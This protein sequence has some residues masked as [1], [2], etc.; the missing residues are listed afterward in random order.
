[1]RSLT[2]AEVELLQS[3]DVNGACDFVCEEESHFSEGEESL[4]R[5]L[6][7]EGRLVERPCP[8]CV[9]R[10]HVDITAKGREALHLHRMLTMPEFAL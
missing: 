9:G 5:R 2:A 3:D 6:V 8:Y 10:S 7:A 1:M 4:L